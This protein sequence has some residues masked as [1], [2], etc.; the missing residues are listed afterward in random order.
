[1]IGN[2]LGMNGVL[3]ADNAPSPLSKIEVPALQPTGFKISVA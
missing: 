3:N 1:M 2:L